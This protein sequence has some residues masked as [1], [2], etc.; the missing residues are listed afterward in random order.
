MTD[1]L[2][3]SDKEYALRNGLSVED[4]LEFK[5]TVMIE[6]EKEAEQVRLEAQWAADQWQDRQQQQLKWKNFINELQQ[7]EDE[8]NDIPTF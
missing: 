7:D 8:Y 5:E 1:I 3:D 6:E 2:T 4:M